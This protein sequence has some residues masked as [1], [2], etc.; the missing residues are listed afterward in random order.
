MVERDSC[1]AGRESGFPS[2]RQYRAHGHI[3]AHRVGFRQLD[4]DTNTNTNTNS[5]SNFSS[6][7]NAVAYADVEPGCQLANSKS[8]RQPPEYTKAQA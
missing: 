6:K 3:T 5:N 8:D 7:P 4:Y 1:C 2:N